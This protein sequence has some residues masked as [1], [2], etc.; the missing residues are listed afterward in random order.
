MLILY[1]ADWLKWQVH[2]PTAR[3]GYGIAMSTCVV[4]V[5]QSLS[6]FVL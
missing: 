3:W 2:T 1:S 6:P 5:L 4:E